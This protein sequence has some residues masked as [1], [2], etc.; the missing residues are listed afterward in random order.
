M[1]GHN[2]ENDHLSAVRTRL[3]KNKRSQLLIAIE[4]TAARRDPLQDKLFP[5]GTSANRVDVVWNW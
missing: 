4:G 5:S 3:A 1:G 2:A